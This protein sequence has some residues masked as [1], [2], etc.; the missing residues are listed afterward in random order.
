MRRFTPYRSPAL[1]RRMFYLT[2]YVKKNK[3]G[4]KKR[5]PPKESA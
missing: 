2:L 4:N 1:K 3:G 5:Q